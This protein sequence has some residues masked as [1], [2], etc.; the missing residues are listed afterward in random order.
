[1][2]HLIS[3]SAGCHVKLAFADMYA[4]LPAL[5]I[6]G[7]VDSMALAYLCSQLRTHDGPGF[8][9]ADNPVSNFRGFV[10]DHRLREGSRE[11]ARNVVREVQKLKLNCELHEASWTTDLGPDID[12]KNLSNLESA[13][14]RVR[15]RRLGRLC[16]YRRI[17]TLLLAHHEDDQYETVL[18]RLMAGHRNRGLRGMRKAAPIPECEGIFGAFESGWIDDPERQHHQLSRP[19]RASLIRALKSSVIEQ[20]D[21]E[22]PGEANNFLLDEDDLPYSDA[23]ATSRLPNTYAT[24]ELDSLP[25][26]DGGVS[27]YR[28]LLEFSKDRLVATCLE[29]NVPW[30][31]DYTNKD[32]T[33]TTRNSIRHMYRSCE[34]PRA[35]QKPSIIALSKAWQRRAASQDAEANRLLQ[36][37]TLHNFEPHVG[38][39]VVQFPPLSVSRPSRYART[40][41]R[42]RRRRLRM[43]LIAALAIQRVIAL[44]CPELQSPPVANLQN[45]VSRL[46]PALAEESVKDSIP[47]KAFNIAGLHFMPI[48]ATPR[49]VNGRGH[50]HPRTW[51]ISRQPY[52]TSMPLPQHRFSYWS[53]GKPGRRSVNRNPWSWSNWLA[54]TYWDN[55][56]WLRLTHRLP[57]RVVIMPFLID[58]AKQFRESLDPQDR[59]KLALI[60]KEIAP[61]KVRYTLPAIYSEEYVDL[62]NV[63]PRMGYPIPEDQ[64]AMRDAA[65]DGDTVPKGGRS[66]PS[67]LSLPPIEPSKFSKMRLLALPTLEIQ[68]PGLEEW[69]L[70][71]TRYRRADRGTLR[72]MG[73]YNESSFD[74]V[75]R[76]RPGGLTSR[77]RPKIRTTKRR[78]RRS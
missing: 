23:W 15:Y 9:I 31:E 44:V 65:R 26:E 73:G 33:L 16:A 69:L 47:P 56:F 25:V 54:W 11:E 51:Y 35:L 5:G 61:G 34:L 67:R 57:Y 77:S 50:A 52:P 58:H 38:T 46:F 29:N 40:S 21:D 62:D 64:Y 24:S 8:P 30:F 39:L 32:P 71:E 49:S 45:V 60:L 10:V 2:I 12:L 36:R 70:Y 27:I 1:M 19:Q 59:N 20:M 4:L 48:E 28:P 22:T 42:Y 41:D 37:A 75:R 53:V 13:A 3:V 76:A 68:L 17:S 6:S 7:G 74:S 63:V 43:R 78:L 66:R 14:R 55:R 18:M 72:V